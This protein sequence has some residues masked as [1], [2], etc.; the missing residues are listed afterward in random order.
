[1]RD[2]VARAV[3]TPDP[4]HVLPLDAVRLLA[5]VPRPGA[6]WCVGYNYR[7]HTA[8]DDPAHP[9]V[10]TKPAS[11]VAG[12]QDPVVLPPASAEVDYEAELAVVIGRRAP[13]AP[14]TGSGTAASGRSARRSPP[15]RRSAR[16]S[17]RPTRSP[18]S[19]T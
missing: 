13:G 5:P 10:F 19:R 14:G 15:S 1:V 16:P 4:A 17:S 8:Q 12:P 2:A 6:I 11:A 7:G 9:D 3:G 18:T